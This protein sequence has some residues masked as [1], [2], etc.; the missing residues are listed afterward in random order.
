MHELAITQSIL[1]IAVEEAKKYNA[2]KVISIRIKIGELSGVVPQ[3]IQEYYNIASRDTIAEMAKLEIE[4]VPIT[5]RC[6]ECGFESGIEK[7]KMKCPE[8][9]SIN[10]KIMTGREFYV[11]SLEVE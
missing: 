6:L 3:L 5:L 1:N 7:L 10:I 8:C 9:S 11:D 2:S 4:R